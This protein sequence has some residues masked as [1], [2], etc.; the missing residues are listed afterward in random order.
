MF[1]QVAPAIKLCLVDMDDRNADPAAAQET[2]CLALISAS[3]ASGQ[4]RCQGASTEGGLSRLYCAHAG[5]RPRNLT[6]PGKHRLR[7]EMPLSDH[8]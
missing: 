8:R 5:R 1:S 6:M 3:R 7:P 2:L 4:L